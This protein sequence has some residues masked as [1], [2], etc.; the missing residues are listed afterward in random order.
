MLKLDL[1]IMPIFKSYRSKDLMKRIFWYHM[2]RWFCMPGVL[3]FMLLAGPMVSLDTVSAMT[4]EVKA[5]AILTADDQGASL[6][7]PSGVFFD[8][9][10]KEVYVINSGRSRIVIYGPDFFP[11]IS[12][13]AGRG[14]D[15]PYGVHVDEDGLLYI[16]QG[17]RQ[18]KPARLTILN[19]AFFPVKEIEFKGFE[20]A[21]RF[22]PRRVALGHGGEIYVAGIN[23]RGV[24]VLDK[25]GNFLRRLTP[26]DTVWSTEEETSPGSEAVPEPRRG[27]SPVLIL[28]VCTDSSGRIY[29]LSEETS[30]VYV[31]DREEN[32]LFSFG[33]KGGSSGKLSR[34]RGLAVDDERDRIYVVD[35]MR[36]TILVYDLT[37]RYLFE[38]GG[39]GWGPGWFNFPTGAAT[40]SRGNLIVA[41]FFNNRVQVLEVPITIPE[42]TDAGV[43]GPNFP[44]VPS[45]KK[46]RSR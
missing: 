10:A 14:V 28:E 34:P 45:S 27:K 17:R 15:A 23:S 36:Q 21:D 3:L 38:F 6:A 46:S 37:G 2:F 20:G 32:F 31:Y 9:T 8:K 7:C 42:L 26:L 25:E 33:K 11:R 39:Q 16:C 5:V 35:Y 44:A 19:A 1:D 24:L 4:S 13:G 41:D 12:L 30:K 29:L 40:D 22:I 18:D 43:A